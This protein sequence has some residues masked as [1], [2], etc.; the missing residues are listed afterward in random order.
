M[1]TSWCRDLEAMNVSMIRHRGAETERG[2]D[3]GTERD[4]AE[5]IPNPSLK[6]AGAATTRAIPKIKQ[7]GLMTIGRQRLLNVPLWSDFNPLL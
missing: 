3:T 2:G 6:P 7:P 5:V 4:A 1:I